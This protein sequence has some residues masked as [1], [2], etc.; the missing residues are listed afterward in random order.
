MNAFHR[1]DELMIDAS[2]AILLALVLCR[3]CG[4]GKHLNVDSHA[5]EEIE[6]A[7]RR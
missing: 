2:T 6:K 4:A 1:G 7:K 5:A 3:F